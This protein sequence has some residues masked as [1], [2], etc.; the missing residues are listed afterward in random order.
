[1][2]QDTSTEPGTKF[3]WGAFSNILASVSAMLLC[4]I[5]GATTYLP[6]VI[7]VLLLLTMILL[8]FVGACLGGAGYFL[9]DRGRGVSIVGLFLNAALFLFISLFVW[10]GHSLL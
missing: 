10:S 9:Q 1:M 4:V 6:P 2:S 7:H 5:L 3:R 8:N